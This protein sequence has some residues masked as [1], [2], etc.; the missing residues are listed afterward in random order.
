[1]PGQRGRSSRGQHRRRLLGKAPSPRCSFR[2]WVSEGLH[3]QGNLPC[4]VPGGEAV[5]GIPGPEPL[6]FPRWKRSPTGVRVS[7]NWCLRN[8][9]GE[10]ARRSSEALVVTVCGDKRP[11]P[12]CAGR[13]VTLQ[14]GQ[15]LLLAGCALLGK[16]VTPVCS[17]CHLCPHLPHCPDSTRHSWHSPASYLY[18][19]ILTICLPFFSINSTKAIMSISCS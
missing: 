9:N 14:L 15:F 10:A 16:D 18:S 12:L 2:P 8:L 7:S 13:E 17:G 6:G 11:F 4:H 5:A 3:E 19:Y 1:M